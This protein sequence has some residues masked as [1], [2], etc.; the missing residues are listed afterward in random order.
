LD[1]LPQSSPST[2]G[3]L[4][5]TRAAALFA[6]LDRLQGASQ[7]QSS[8]GQR[9]IFW[10]SDRN[11]AGDITPA[12]ADAIAE[13]V[14]QGGSLL[15][16]FG[17]NP[18]WHI[19]LLSR[20]LPAIPWSAAAGRATDYGPRPGI[21]IS[22]APTDPE[23]FPNPS[24]QA[25]RLPFFEP[26]RPFAA[27]ERGQATYERY[28]QTIP[29]INLQV[30]PG[31]HFWSRP[32]INRQW[33]VRLTGDDVY[34]SPLLL[35]GLYGAGRVAVFASSASATDSW[36][37]A[38]DFW[39]GVLQWL[40]GRGPAQLGGQV[41]DGST[42][43]LAAAVTGTGASSVTIQ[44]A[45]GST[46]AGLLVTRALTTE[47]ALIGASETE[48]ETRV[49]V[50]A[51]GSKTFPVN[52]PQPSPISY[53]SLV[54][55]PAVKLRVGLLSAAGSDLIVESEI[56]LSIGSPLALSVRTDNLYKWQYPFAA[57]APEDIT[58]LLTRMGSRI[59][60]YCYPPGAPVQC[61]VVVSNGVTNLAPLAAIADETQPGNASVMALN[62]GAAIQ[63]KGPID[64]IVGYGAWVGLANRENALTLTF[65][66]PMRITA[67]TLVG[68]GSEY[69][70]G[71]DHNPG[72][73]TI[74]ADGIQI[75]SLPSIDQNFLDGYGRAR[76]EL[77]PMTTATTLRIR[78][79]WIPMRADR[80]RQIPWLG[81]I[82]VD[83]VLAQA[84]PVS[85]TLEVFLRDALSEAAATPV[86]SQQIRLAPGARQTVVKSLTLPATTGT[87]FFTLE[88]RFS[89]AK[90]Q[91]PIMVIAPSRP[92]Q[93]RRKL[94]PPDAP[95][96]GQLVTHG[97]RSCFALGTGTSEINVA[98]GSPDDLIWAY[99]RQ[100]K[101]EGR[102][103]KTEANR[104]YV[105]AGDMRHYCT[106]WAVFSNGQDFYEAAT[107]GL[108]ATMSKQR[109]W[110]TSPVAILY[111]SDRWDSGPQM[112]G[113]NQW[114]EF[115][116]FDRYLRANGGAG[117]QSRTRTAVADEIHTKY[118]PQWQQWHLDR[119]VKNIATLRQAFAQAGKQLV[120]SAQGIPMVAGPE[121][122]GLAETIKGAA[123]DSTWGMTDNSIPLT[124]GRQM[125]EIAFNPVWKLSTLL[126][127]GF[128]TNFLNSPQWHAPAGTLEPSRRHTYD[129]AWRATIWPDGRYGS[130]Y[131]F[132]YSEN[133]GVGY[134]L[135][136]D[137]WQQWWRMHQRHTLIAPE[138]P[139]GAGLVLATSFRASGPQMQF[140]GGGEIGE[141]GPEVKLL[142]QVFRRLHEA[143]ISIPFAAN[144]SALASWSGTAPLIVVNLWQFSDAEVATLAQLQA[145]GIPLA[146][147]QS[148]QPLGAEANALLQRPGVT[149]LPVQA[150]ALLPDTAAKITGLLRQSLSPPIVFPPGTAGY[151]FRSGGIAYI[152]VEDWQEQGREIQ[153]QLKAS[154]SASTA[155]ACDGNDHR[156]LSIARQGG[157]WRINTPIRPGDGVLIAISE[158]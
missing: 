153:I 68:C 113:M 79:P 10:E 99:S 82:E 58:A 32:L 47:G 100:L 39:T 96:I 3:N 91:T 26:L 21:G 5:R 6:A 155:Y 130:V 28:A 137:D 122:T 86:Y 112:S 76:I 73:A 20:M 72:A 54:S 15:L 152:V 55:N 129:R 69:R 143:G 34:A 118:E 104:L 142:A 50:P 56:P 156:P 38:A 52:L 4:P 125:G 114:Q 136:E 61:E 33:K 144:I 98:W 19:M 94:L 81:E 157:W 40:L 117:L 25:Q 115:V 110:A 141:V 16:S 95:A 107:P 12:Q 87:R 23:L 132:G 89:G 17:A 8:R 46:L 97:F 35:T 60:A 139:I 150:S 154:P 126:E 44:N 65:P 149:L 121:A 84:T 53:H 14:R 103:A 147:F 124:T 93:S 123:D 106:P 41:P 30:P 13:S 75:A 9:P 101:Q 2:S 119:Y 105:T 24:F 48:S 36:H 49:T 63:E 45:G 67:L 42:V 37:G 29:Y 77:P 120:L 27:V 74:E 128:N 57:A 80:R 145:R 78:L 71:L 1:T 158:I 22:A 51:G 90:S 43:R 18:Q 135:S 133:V 31:S 116:E 151:G 146:V 7:P 92:I 66:A 85:G 138:S 83:G 134:L 109:N 111:H 140:S 127:Y 62:D 70:L 11:A 102:N 148:P 108:V 64:G 131:S 88:A 59:N